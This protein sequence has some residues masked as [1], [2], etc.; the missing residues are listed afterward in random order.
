[1]T[2]LVL[3]RGKT[4]ALVAEVARDRGH[5]VRVLGGAQNLAAKALTPEG[6][7]EV[8]AVVDFTTPDAVLANIRACVH[9]G[10]NMVVGTTGWQEHLQEVREL[11]EKSGTGLLYGTNF[12]IGVNIF[13]DVARSAAVAL[14]HKY[15]GEIMERHHAQKKDAPS[16]TALRLQ[17]II[18]EVSGTE[19][20]IISFREGDV[21]GLHEVVLDCP[22]DSIRLA[23][24]AKSRRGFA[25]GAVLGA[26]WL[27]GKKGFYDF[28]DVWREL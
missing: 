7:R 21:V 4:G 27:A 28:Q 17:K 24:D 23:H 19:L 10:K 8:N 13:Y 1:M 11:V 5:R 16:G 3:G 15:F 9:A 2:I 20:E 6:L 22:N 14:K 18:E 26:E 12:S 25:E